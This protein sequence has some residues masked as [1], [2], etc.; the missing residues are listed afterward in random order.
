M[1]MTSVS[2]PMVGYV[3]GGRYE[4]TG[5]IARGGMAVVYRAVDLRLAR[6]VA[7]KLMHDSLGDNRDFALK[8]DREARA[9][10]RLS[11][12]PS[13]VSVF[14]Q[15]R[16]VGRPY[17]VMEYVDGETLRTKLTREAPLAPLRALEIMDPVVGALACAHQHGIVHRD[18][19]PENVMISA[20]GQ[21]KVGDFGLA[22]ALS[23]DAT[24]TQG[25]LMGTV[26]Y[27]SPELVARGHCDA[28]SDLYSV[29]IMLFELLTGRK[30]YVGDSAIHIAY[31][32]CNNDVPP[33]S[34]QL[35]PAA[36]ARVRIPGYV[37]ALVQAAAARDPQHRP[38][39]AA[40]LLRQ[41]RLARAALLRGVDDDPELEA[42]IRSGRTP[43]SPRPT[44]MAPRPDVATP[45]A[46]T[47]ARVPAPA[48]PPA[49]Q[50]TSR[51]SAAAR[52]CTSRPSASRPAAPSPAA[53]AP[54]SSTTPRAAA[55]PVARPRPSQAAIRLRAVAVLLVVVGF[56]ALLGAGAWFVLA[57][58]FA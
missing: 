10:A 56:A 11:Q 33:P 4:I 57:L 21:V 5:R 55:R 19:K 52:P 44:A 20:R 32:H 28:R 40:T 1:S 35:P 53:P 6:A 42:A 8:F 31:A 18:V 17:I 51:A 15:G 14:D 39:D 54:R 45:T 58:L 27:I 26:S 25:I 36:A 9:A 38:A 22:K 46:R 24:A 13:V 34:T 29:G 23:T 50:T 37:D 49:Q 16:D 7:L 3:L 12:C 30:P 2:D 47:D 43:R 41:L 48:T